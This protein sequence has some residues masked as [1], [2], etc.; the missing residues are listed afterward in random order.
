[1][2]LERPALMRPMFHG[3][4]ALGRLSMLLEE[5][6]ILLKKLITIPIPIEYVIIP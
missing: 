1:M 4:T 2:L 6:I 5:F 3:W